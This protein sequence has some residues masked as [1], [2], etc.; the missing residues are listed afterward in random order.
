MRTLAKGNNSD[1][2]YKLIKVLI[3]TQQSDYE[4]ALAGDT[5]EILDVASQIETERSLFGERDK[6]LASSSD[7]LDIQRF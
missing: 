2:I 1:C 3:N 4:V 7:G 5:A 6:L